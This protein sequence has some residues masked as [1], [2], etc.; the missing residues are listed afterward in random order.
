MKMS[1]KAEGPGRITVGELKGLLQNLPQEASVNFR[2]ETDPRDGQG[3]WSLTV[4]WDPEELKNG[5]PFFSPHTVARG[6]SSDTTVIGGSSRFSGDDYQGV[7]GMGPMGQF[8]D[9]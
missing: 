3:Y 5:T 6:G 4:E 2:S 8:G 7:G 9:H 1:A